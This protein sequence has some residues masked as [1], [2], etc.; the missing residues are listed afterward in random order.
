M[1]LKLL[2][3]LSMKAGSEDFTV[4]VAALCSMPKPKCV[5]ALTPVAVNILKRSTA[6]HAESE[7]CKVTPKGVTVKQE[8]H[9]H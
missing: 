9:N 4:T 3:H 5:V 1:G 8:A 6:G 7:A 2:H